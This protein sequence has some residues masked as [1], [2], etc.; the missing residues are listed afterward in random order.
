VIVPQ[1]LVGAD[2]RILNLAGAVT[3]GAENVVGDPRMGPNLYRWRL[4]RFGRATPVYAVWG[5]WY[6]WTGGGS[7]FDAVPKTGDVWYAFTS[8]GKCLRD[9]CPRTIYRYEGIDGRIA[10]HIPG[11]CPLAIPLD[12]GWQYAGR[13]KL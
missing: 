7:R 12:A 6:T 10:D 5:P 9:N 11:R 4:D 3:D 1:A 8:Q 2:A 13:I